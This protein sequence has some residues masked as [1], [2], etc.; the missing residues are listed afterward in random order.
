M[1]SRVT[2]RADAAWVVAAGLFLQ[3]V[4]S[5]QAP[6]TLRE[7][8][9]RARTVTPA[10]RVL[11]AAAEE[12]DARVR[13]A[14]A[15]HLPRVEASGGLQRSDH[16]V[17]VFSSLLA[18]RRF[19]AADFDLAALNEPSPTSNV[20]A[21]V[22]VEQTVFDGGR[23]RFGVQAAALER[24]RTAE[25][26]SAAQ[27]DLAVRAAEAFV[28][29]L[30]L[31]VTER[32]HAAALA[33]AEGDVSRAR[34]RRDAG[35]VTEADVLAAEVFL[36]DVQGRRITTRG[37]L[38][39]ARLQL[40]EIIGEP[41]GALVTLAR[42]LPPGAGVDAAAL[43][44]EALRLRPERKDAA[45]RIA[46]AD[47]ERRAARAAFLPTVAVE[48]G[49]EANGGTWSQPRSSWLVGVQ[50]RLDVF[51]GFRTVARQAEAQAAGRRALA[52]DEEIARRIQVEVYAA[53]ARLE[54]A[55]AREAAGR[56]ALAQARES[57]RIVR[58]RYESGL[59]SVTDL[60][61]AAEALLEAES[62]ATTAETDA[63]LG[64]VLLDRAVG[65]L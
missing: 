46:R 45:L 26:R 24:D 29:T 50:A 36:A 47:V 14:R 6:L 37:E 63:M 64:A 31:E 13:Q 20:R 3:T 44:E 62:R 43:A 32:V 12:A 19:T 22:R 21:A 25:G 11:D 10:A 40:N 30:Q 56:A 41:L 42:P 39:V 17:F 48:G 35:L 28:R 9:D 38:A 61:R 58:D 4:V 7:A 15:G 60:L 23:T 65:R 33:T 52:A 8:M 49:L 57:H 27:Q 18:Q 5:A 51:D 59:A 16:P 53:A 2:Y 1:T 34:A 54:A 55:L